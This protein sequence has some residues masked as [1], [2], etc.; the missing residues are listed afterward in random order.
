MRNRP[1]GRTGL[2]V[3]ELCLGTM[4]FG[5]GEGIACGV[6][7][8]SLAQV[9][10][11][12]PLNMAE[13]LHSQGKNRETRLFTAMATAR[14]TIACLDVAAAAGYVSESAVKGPRKEWDEIVAI[15]YRLIELRRRQ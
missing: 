2:F 1:L 12:V 7:A 9:G 14:E 11:S 6:D 10:M 15:L 13:G 4:T 3:S 8:I 5:G